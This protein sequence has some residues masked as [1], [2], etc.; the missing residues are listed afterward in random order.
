MIVL[1]ANGFVTHATLSVEK[2][3]SEIGKEPGVPNRDAVSGDKLEEL[4]DNVLDVGN[5]FEVAG[6]RGE[7]VADAVQ[8]EELLLLVGVKETEGG[9]G[10]VTQH[11]TL[12]SVSEGKLTERGFVGGGARA[13]NFCSFHGELRKRNNEVTK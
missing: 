12:A 11:A 1:R 5:G 9:V 3:L 2:K 8:R 13:G 7:F 6:E 10:S 4:A